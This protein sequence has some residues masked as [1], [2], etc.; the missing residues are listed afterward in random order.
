M[1]LAENGYDIAFSHWNDSK[2]ADCTA[3]EVKQSYQR[4]CAVFEGNLENEDEPAR[5]V[6]GAIQALGHIDMLV[7]NAGVTIFRPVTEM[8][9]ESMNRL[10]HLD[11]R[12]PMLLIREVGRHMI[13]KG[14][15]GSIINITS[16]R[17]ERAY[18]GDAVYGGVKAALA[19][20]TGSVAL[21]LAAHGIR[22]NCIAP[23]AIQTSADREAYYC[24]FGAKIPLG[25]PGTP[26]DIG[27]AAV[28]LASEQASYMTGAVLRVD[29]GLI[30]PGMPETAD[31][32]GWRTPE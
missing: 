11:F 6:Q 4:K 32:P 18:A 17:S 28:W 24:G 15:Q 2:N 30:L 5:L 3:A 23:G 27:K 25:R 26:D 19:R 29:G 7:N 31:G 10:L 16:T 9:I 22:V 14:I 20:A 21:D 13:A 1:A 8:D 12:A